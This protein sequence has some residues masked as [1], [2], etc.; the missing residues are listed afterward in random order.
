M[1]HFV[2]QT[3]RQH[4]VALHNEL[5]NKQNMIDYVAFPSRKVASTA[6]PLFIHAKD[7]SN[8]YCDVWRP[9]PGVPTERPVHLR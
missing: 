5:S 3:V 7:G 9:V 8:H 1:V 4:I 6:H 2:Y